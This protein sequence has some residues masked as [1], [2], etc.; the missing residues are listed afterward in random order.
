MSITFLVALVSAHSGDFPPS[1]TG[2][3]EWAHVLLRRCPCIP[4]ARCAVTDA[5]VRREPSGTGIA[6]KS[7]R[8][9]TRRQRPWDREGGFDHRIG[10]VRP[11]C[12][13]G[14]PLA[15]PCPPVPACFGLIQTMWHTMPP[16]DSKG[17]AN[18]EKH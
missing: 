9:S 14:S 11:R 7:T 5:V 4:L 17:C 2:G 12:R 16:H 13:T 18:L 3:R 8:S 15:L 1:K 6:A 10:H